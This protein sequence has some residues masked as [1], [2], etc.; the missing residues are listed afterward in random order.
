MPGANGIPPPGRLVT[1]FRCWWA[2]VQEAA[3]QRVQLER[4]VRHDRRRLLV[5]AL[6]AWRA[7]RLWG[8]RKKVALRVWWGQS[9]REGLSSNAGADA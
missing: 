3:W 7:Y 4:A 8:A 6:G 9:W 2:R 5:W 1:C